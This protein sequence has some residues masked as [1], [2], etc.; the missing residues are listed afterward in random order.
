MHA[1]LELVA[2]VGAMDRFVPEDQFDDLRHV[3]QLV[4]TQVVEWRVE[5][6]VEEEGFQEDVGHLL[7][8]WVFLGIEVHVG[9]LGGL[10]LEVLLGIRPLEDLVDLVGGVQGGENGGVTLGV[11]RLHELD[12]VQDGGLMLGLDVLLE[13]GQA[14]LGLD[15]IQEGQPPEDVPNR[16]A[17][18]VVQFPPVVEVI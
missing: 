17:V 18:I 7:L 12:V 3:V 15:G 1:N 14:G 4:V 2:D 6:R 16:P 13:G 5:A 9:N 11:N 8:Q 10:V